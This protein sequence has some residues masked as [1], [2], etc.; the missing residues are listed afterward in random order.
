MELASSILLFFISCV[1]LHLVTLTVSQQSFLRYNCLSDKGDILHNQTA[2]LNCTVGTTYQENLNGLLL[3][4][5]SNSEPNH[6]FYNFSAGRNSE[7]VNVITLCRGD[8]KPDVR[9]SCIRDSVPKLL[10]VCCNPKELIGYYDDCMLRFSNR[11]ICETMEVSPRYRMINP[12]NVTSLDQFNQ[13]LRTLLDGL[14]RKAASGGSLRKFSTR[15]ISSS[16]FKTL[17]GLV[18]CTPELFERQCND[19]LHTIYGRIRDCC[20]EKEGA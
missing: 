18:Q 20:D 1:L 9:S 15:N 11:S 5:F 12:E 8:V 14:R 16:D 6:G 7:K 4:G 19:C 17:Y 2:T 10:Q 3:S 13:A